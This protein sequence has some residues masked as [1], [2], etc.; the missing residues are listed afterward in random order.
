MILR[1]LFL[2]ALIFG[3]IAYGFQ[4][5]TEQ[6]LAPFHA[7][8][9]MPFFN[10]GK[11]INVIGEKGIQLK[12]YGFIQSGPASTAIVLAPGWG[13]AARKY[14]EVTY[15][16]YEAGYSVFVMDHRGQ[17]ESQRIINC[18]CSYVEDYKYYVEDLAK[19][20]R[21]EVRPHF[22]KVF[23]VGHSMGGG[24]S[25]NLVQRYPEI[26]DGAVLS[27]PMLQVITDPYN[28][29]VA[30]S[31]TKAMVMIGKGKERRLFDKD[32]PADFAT[33]IGTHSEVRYKISRDLIELNP[34]LKTGWATNRWLNEVFEM[35][36]NIRKSKD[37]T[38]V[39]VMILQSEVDK[40]VVNSTQNKLCTAWKNCVLHP[41]PGTL[42]EILME[43]DAA[44]N[45][46]LGLIK[47][48][49]NKN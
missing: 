41:I 40:Y 43:S 20:I 17:G 14:A 16:L 49:V 48:F 33:N 32:K 35:T 19:F 26:I 37:E 30:Q 23:L 25:A 12:G 22:T 9:I 7:N 27:S 47:E 28:E 3:Q 15:D 13:E 18:P 31:L 21:Q 42:H 1:L 45:K 6:N 4:K 11:Q 38:K 10:S 44:R 5:P 36:N 2:G 34:A 39:P 8:T 29:V 24:I 46:A